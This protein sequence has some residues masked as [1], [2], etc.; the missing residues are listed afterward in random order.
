MEFQFSH[1]FTIFGMDMCVFGGVFA[2]SDFDL[3]L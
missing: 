2:K 1:E 3:V